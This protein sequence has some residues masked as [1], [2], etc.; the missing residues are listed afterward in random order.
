MNKVTRRRFLS[1]TGKKSIGLS[2]AIA[3]LPTSRTLLA[4]KSPDRLRLAVV[5]L[6]GRGGSHARNYAKRSDCEIVYLCDVDESLFPMRVSEVEKNQG[7]AP[8]VVGD[9]RRALDDKSIDAIIIATPDHWHALATI[10]GCQAGKDVYVEKPISHSPWEGRKMV[11]AARR[12]KRIVQVGTQNRS[13]HY[14]ILAKQY[15]ESGKLGTL[16]MVRVYNQK[17]WPNVPALADRDPP[18]NLNWDMWTGPAPASR[19]NQNYHNSWN[20]FW[21]F[22]GGDIINDGIHQMDL[23]RWLSG[24]T[25][26]KSVYSTGGRYAEKGVHESPDTQVAVFQY[27][28]M[29]MTFELTLY[30]PYMLKSDQALRDSDMYPYW[31][32]NGERIEL[33]GSKGLMVLG[34]HGCGW[35]VFGRPKDRQPVV[36]HQENGPFPD[37]EHM[38]NFVQCLRSRQTPNADIEEGHRSTF[39]CQLANISYRLGGRKLVVNAETETLVDDAE[40]NK[41]LRREYR[42]PWVV[43]EKV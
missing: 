42:S 30:T 11:E 39:M 8:K 23:A 12:H 28:D 25:Y 7:K 4:D 36:V 33:Y 29:V 27:D 15:I 41:M 31:P 13:A 38:R 16:H 3:A 10:W 5:G 6:R 34:R 35:Q 22:S 19:Y 18:A 32:Q 17:E 1:S 21:R 26:P 24:K 37:T 40:A 2:A 43:P 20:H 9:F 14:N